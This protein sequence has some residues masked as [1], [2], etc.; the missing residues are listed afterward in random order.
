M[1]LLI[2]LFDFYPIRL[3]IAESHDQSADDMTLTK[4]VLIFFKLL[5]FIWFSNPRPV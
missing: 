3:L 5:V 1:K 4:F 2:L